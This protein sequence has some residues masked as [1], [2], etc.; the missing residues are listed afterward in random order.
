MT[1]VITQAQKRISLSSDSSRSIKT[2]E[3]KKDEDFRIY[4]ETTSN[5]R[6]VQHYKDMR[7]FQTVAFYRKMEAKYSFD[8]GTYRR[9]M[10]I[11]EAFDELEHYVVRETSQ[12]SESFP[13]RI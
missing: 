5:P 10:T 13:S 2:N 1:V 7:M 11:E 4:D 12:L 6:V 9:L 3:N 8:N